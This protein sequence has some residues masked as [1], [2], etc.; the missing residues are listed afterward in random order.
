MRNEKQE[1]PQR[2]MDSTI[3]FG[4]RDEKPKLRSEPGARE[5]DSYSNPALLLRTSIIYTTSEPKER[6][7]ISKHAQAENKEGSS[8]PPESK[9]NKQTVVVTPKG[10]HGEGEARKTYRRET[11]H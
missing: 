4:R 1:P 3:F 10:R 6:A 11:C 5:A 8:R 9:K 7:D 2:P